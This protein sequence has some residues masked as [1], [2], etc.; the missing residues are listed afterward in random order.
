MSDECPQIARSFP[1]DC[2]QI[3]RIFAYGAFGQA[4]DADYMTDDIGDSDD[5]VSQ[6]M[7][8][9]A[10]MLSISAGK[11]VSVAMTIE[12]LR[13]EIQSDTLYKYFWQTLAGEVQT[14]KYVGEAIYNYL[15][16]SLTVSESEL[17]LYKGSRFLVP[18][19]L[20]PGLLKALHIG[21]PGVLSM[22]LRAKE[23]FWWSGLKQ[24][25][26]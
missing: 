12:K 20:R 2:S 4:F 26:V 11:Q 15:K 10:S 17:I 9:V 21:H 8:K 16:D 22:I 14:V 1:A 25:I 18:R 6:V 23:T 24:D 3:A 13:A 5:Y 7:S 19:V